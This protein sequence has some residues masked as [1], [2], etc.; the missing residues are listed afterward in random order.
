MTGKITDFYVYVTRGGGSEDW[1]KEARTL[2]IQLCIYRQNNFSMP[3]IT[4]E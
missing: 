1:R 3:Y 4:E 2:D